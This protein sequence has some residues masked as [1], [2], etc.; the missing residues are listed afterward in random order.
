M[1]TPEN[2]NP[3]DNLISGYLNGELTIDETKELLR[4]LKMDPANK[5]Y[6]DEYCELWITS[7]SSLKNTGYSYQQG[8]WKFKQRIKAG[9]AVKTDLYRMTRV[10]TFFKYAAVIVVAFTISGLIFYKIGRN[11]VIVPQQSFSELIVPMGSRAQ[12]TLPDGTTV[13][14]NAGSRLKY[15]ER[16]GIND[17]IVELEGEGYFKVAKDSKRLFTVKTS[18]L[19]VNALGTAFNI[20]AYSDDNTIETTL[21]EGSVRIEEIADNGRK[22]VMVL[23]PNQKLTFFKADLTMVGESAVAK[24]K[25][26]NESAKLKIQ[27][28][29][30]IPKLVKENVNVDPVI[31]WK[32]NRWIFENQSLSDIATDL[33]RRFD[34]KIHFES[35][36]LKNFRFTG[37]IIA[38]P[39]EQVLQVMSISAPISFKLK[40]K[41]VTL[42]E[43]KSVREI[44]KRLYKRQ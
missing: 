25:T 12:F 30:P 19:N 17:R 34:V 26:G 1:Q 24:E 16:F 5:R 32:D 4:W 28:A 37:I 31:S 33:E 9:E 40:G 39:I 41:V 23:K 36:Q 20:K 13:S 29:I 10:K 14:L 21:V 2:T 3:A 35:E 43:N 7:R 11:Q 18:Y 44:N 6:Y 42:S 27:K 22:E 15:D 38:E 8:F